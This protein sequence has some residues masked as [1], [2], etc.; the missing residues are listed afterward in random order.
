MDNA[1]HAMAST[2]NEF[3]DLSWS[4]ISTCEPREASRESDAMQYVHVNDDEG[5][6]HDRY[7]SFPT[8]CLVTTVKLIMPLAV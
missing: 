7:Y 1:E 4:G 6:G 2:N 5:M 8:L 3:G